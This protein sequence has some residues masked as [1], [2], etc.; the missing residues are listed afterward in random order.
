MGTG[1]AD[2]ARKGRFLKC[3]RVVLMLAAVHIAVIW[4]AWDDVRAVKT[5]VLI[6]S[7]VAGGFAGW[8]L[9]IADRK[10][11]HLTVGA[12]MFL[13]VGSALVGQVAN[14][15]LRDSPYELPLAA[16]CLGLISVLFLTRKGPRLAAP[17]GYDT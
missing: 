8:G 15:L 14:W 5:G 16:L 7:H 12:W 13:A 17:H 4:L 2:W 11:R 1:P 6:G 3:A 10:A 9:R